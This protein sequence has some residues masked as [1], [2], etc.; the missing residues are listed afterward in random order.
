MTFFCW[1]G[2]VE[3]SFDEEKAAASCRP[4]K[5]DAGLG[6]EDGSKERSLH[7]AA[8]ARIRERR[9]KPTASVGMTVGGVEPLRHD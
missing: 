9:K 6:G 5:Q 8:G 1:G 7:C 3:A 4:P 2:D